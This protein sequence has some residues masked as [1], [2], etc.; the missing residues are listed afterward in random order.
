MRAQGGAEGYLHT[1][2][3][4]W[5]EVSNRLQIPTALPLNKEPSVTIEQVPRWDPDSICMW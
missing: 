4:Y 1:Q 2:P 5:K 3:Q